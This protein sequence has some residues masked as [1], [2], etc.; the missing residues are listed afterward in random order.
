MT[1]FFKFYSY[2]QHYEKTL[3]YAV[4]FGNFYEEPRIFMRSLFR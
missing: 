1:F 2:S 4:L 3:F